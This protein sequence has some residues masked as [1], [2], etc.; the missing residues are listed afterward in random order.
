M[1]VLRRCALG[2][3]VCLALSCP[4]VVA[5]QQPEHL[6]LPEPLTLEYAL[7]LA[8]AAHPDLELARAALDGAVADQQAVESAFGTRVG[9]EVAL[10]AVDPTDLAR[11]AYSTHNDSWAKLTASKRLYDFGATAAA[12]EAAA[13]DV[14]GREY[15][16]LGARQQRRLEIMRR[17]FD[18]ILADLEYA[19]DNEAMAAA[20]VS[21][22]K[23][24]QR[25]ELGQ[26][27]DVVLLQAESRYQSALQRRTLSQARQRAARSRLALVLNRPGD[28]STNLERPEL[29]AVERQV[30]EL[31]PL[32][33]A[34][35]DAT[36]ELQ[37]LRAELQAAEERVRAT[38]LRYRG[39]LRGELQA[40]AYNREFARDDPFSAALVLEIPL[41]TG[42]EMD[43]ELARQRALVRDRRAQILG[44]EL[45]IRQVVL[46]LWLEIASLQAKRRELSTLGRFRDLTLDRT[47]ALYELEVT[48]DLGDSM[49]GTSEQ[50][51]QDAQTEFQLALAWARL[52]ALTGRL[53]GDRSD[54]AEGGIAAEEERP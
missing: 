11:L 19:R 51:L 1:A 25:N 7:S 44:K 16:L 38:R 18:V 26:V 45:E 40:A 33:E 17:Y 15:V 50:R 24:Q 4:G 42:G 52:D 14:R 23:V 30:G 22:D 5:Q 41:V 47:R 9:V 6:P 32:V 10:R 49:V 34:A 8:D 54:V 21:F 13:A 20:Y 37:A 29:D 27:S 43:A 46:E 48:S 36:P 2:V 12:G 31:D 53:V 35:L 39:E 28:L 3:P